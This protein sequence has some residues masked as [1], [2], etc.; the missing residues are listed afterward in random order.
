[1]CAEEPTGILTHHRIQD[2]A[3]DAFLDRLTAVSLAHP[4]VLW[5]DAGEIFAPEMGDPV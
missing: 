4:A 2:E 5:L 3:T 1:V